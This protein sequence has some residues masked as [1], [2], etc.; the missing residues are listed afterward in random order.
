MSITAREVTSRIAFQSRALKMPAIREV[1]ADLADRAR[2]EGWSHE[3]Y[4]AQVLDRQMSQREA[5]GLRNRLARAHLP[6]RKTLA[7]FNPD[8]QRSLSRETLA[9]L[10]TAAF[11]DKADNIILLGPPGVGK[12]HLAQ[13]LAIA[14]IEAGHSAIFDTATGWLERLT[15]AHNQGHFDAEVRKLSRYKVLVID[16]VGY[17]PFDAA[18][19]NLFFQL[20]ASRY[21]QASIIITSN[22]PFGRWGEIF[23]DDT[24]AA[25]MIDRLIHHSEVIALDGESYR[26]KHRKTLLKQNK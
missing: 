11:A 19:A 14:A 17:I 4:L 9:Y 3:E 22:L 20:I 18:A 5:A 21:E 12:T 13:G 23:S 2:L 8:Y 25:A 15:Q 16:E 6:S 10:S 26:T 1:A 7:D 24:I